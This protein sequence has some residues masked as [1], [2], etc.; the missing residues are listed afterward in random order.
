M[1]AEV[2]SGTAAGDPTAFGY[3]KRQLDR[4]LA[5]HE[6]MILCSVTQ[7]QDSGGEI[8]LVIFYEEKGGEEKK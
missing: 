3:L 1:K 5:E 4:F 7:S 2:L 8:T 6:Q